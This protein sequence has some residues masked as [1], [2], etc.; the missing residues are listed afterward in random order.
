MLYTTQKSDLGS[1]ALRPQ[2]SDRFFKVSLLRDPHTVLAA[3]IVQ[4]FL[5]VL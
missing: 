5:N 3:E 2:M 1:L 4:L